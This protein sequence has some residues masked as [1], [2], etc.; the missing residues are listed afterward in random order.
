MQILFILISLFGSTELFNKHGKKISEDKQGK[1]GTVSIIKDRKIA[2]TIAQN[3]KDGKLATK[4][5]VNTGIKTTKVVLSEALHTLKRTENNGGL[6]EECSVVTAT[7]RV[8]RGETGDFSDIKNNI[9]IAE[10]EL[11]KLS[12]NE[13]TKNATSIHSHLIEVK[14]ENS[15][16]YS[17][18]ITN[19]SFDPDLWTFTNYGTNIIVGNLKNSYVIWTK[20]E[21]VTINSSKG[22]AIYKKGRGDKPVLV[23]RER[24]VVKIIK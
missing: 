16:F 21:F 3:F 15:Y 17:H 13:S 8:V 2:K 19:P 6:R 4:K 14:I 20:N 9:H 23:L 18:I 10:V 12:N 11:P 1:D 5:E 7:G 22:L 24:A